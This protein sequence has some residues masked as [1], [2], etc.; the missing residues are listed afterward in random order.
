MEFQEHSFSERL[1]REQALR[2]GASALRGLSKNKSQVI[3]LYKSYK[4]IRR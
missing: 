2:P 1:A 4:N 3:E